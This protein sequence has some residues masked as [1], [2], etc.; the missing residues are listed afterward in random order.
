MTISRKR[1]KRSESYLGIHF[2]FHADEQSTEVGKHTTREMIADMLEKVR[3]D[4]IQIDCKGH[5]GLSSYP[6]MVGHQAPGIIG[7]PLRTWREVTAEQGV[8]LYMHYS[9]VWDTAAITHH[10][11]WARIDAEGKVDPDNTSVFGPYVDELL[12]PQLT[13]LAEGYGV[14]GVWVDGECWAT[15]HDYGEQ[16]LRLFREETNIDAVPR[17]PED[18]YYYEFSEFQREAFRRYLRHYVD[19]LH[20]I[21]PDF[22]IASNWAFSSQMPE[23]VSAEVDFISGDYTLQN[24]VHSA[25]LEGRCM[26]GRGKPWDLMAWA[27][28]CKFGEGGWCVTTKTALQLQ[29]EAAQVL[30]LGGGF[31]AYFQQKRKDGSISR[32]QMNVMMEVAAFCR[33]RQEVCHRATAVPQIA[34][35]YSQAAYYR[36][37]TRLFNPWDGHLV[38]LQGVLNNLL[39][40]QYAVEV[41]QEYQLLADMAKYPLIV[42]PEWGY[43][44]DMFRVKLLQYVKNGGNLLVIGPQAAKLFQEELDIKLLGDGPMEVAQWLEHNG[45]LTGLFTM[46][47]AVQLGQSAT[48]YGRLFQENDNI[49]ASEAAASIAAYGHGKIAATFF[50]MGERYVNA[51]TTVTRDFLNGIVRELFPDPIVEVKGS[52]HVDVMVN[53]VD[54]SGKLAVHLVNTSGPHANPNVYTYDEIPTVGPL[55][56]SVRVDEQPAAV[57]LEP[58][59]QNLAFNYADG[60]VKLTLPELDIHR[61]LVFEG[62]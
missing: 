29:Q 49:G 19:E 55:E 51:A 20:R 58:G 15:S 45:K 62:V 36:Q 39:D 8:S 60:R 53:R 1:L 28:S 7:D 32:W 12:I 11:E 33:E 44:E 23:P 59:G 40:A 22:E 38:P 24:S 35:L 41:K 42:I 26:A 18:P 6:T 57:T 48:P 61:I 2:D 21:K 3:P 13:E 16:S 10:P 50:N 54:G 34:L 17:S 25:R 9:G 5:R 14:D 31:Q 56:V 46:S 47:Q 30:A 37:N 4:Y 43:L 52:R 27:F